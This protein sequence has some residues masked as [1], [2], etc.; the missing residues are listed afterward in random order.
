MNSIVS[1]RLCKLPAPE[2]LEKVDKLT[3]KMYETG[4]IPIRHIPARPDSD[5][6]LLIGELIKRMQE[7]EQFLNEI[8]S[9]IS[10]GKS[11]F[12]TSDMIKDKI[13]SF[14]YC[15]YGKSNGN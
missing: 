15:P 14:L 12:N 1:F 3:D 13:S 6:D 4:Q 2:L 8:E 5:Y 10:E 9:D 7:M 11:I